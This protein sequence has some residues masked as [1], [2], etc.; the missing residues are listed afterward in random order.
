MPNYQCCSNNSLSS[1]MEIDVSNF[2][3]IGSSTLQDLSLIQCL[4]SS[5]NTTHS[6][7]FMV[8]LWPGQLFAMLETSCFPCIC[9]IFG[10]L[11]SL[12]SDGPKM[13]FTLCCDWFV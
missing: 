10:F 13:N 9:F 3:T 8:V 6:N 12:R 4:W 2:N 1:F 11:D 7:M 5:V